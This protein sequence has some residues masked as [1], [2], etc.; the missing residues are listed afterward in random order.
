M[1]SNLKYKMSILYNKFI[2]TKININN[3]HNKY[4]VNNEY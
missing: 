4:N 2:F 3:F 1:M